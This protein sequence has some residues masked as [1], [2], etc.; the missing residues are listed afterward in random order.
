LFKDVKKAQAIYET[1]EYLL[2][3]EEEV[4]KAQ[5]IYGTSEAVLKQMLLLEDAGIQYF[6]VNLE[7]SRE[8]DALD[9]FVNDIMK[10]FS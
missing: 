2:R 7:A 6:I 1:S 10:K 5:A 3:H 9:I 4:K 8:L